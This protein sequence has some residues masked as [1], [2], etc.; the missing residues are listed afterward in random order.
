MMSALK[1]MKLAVCWLLVFFG[2]M[3]QAEMTTLILASDV[4]AWNFSITL[5]GL[6]LEVDWILANIA[7][8]PVPSSSSRDQPYQRG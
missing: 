8:G 1:K 6:I 7:A 5:Q 4:S 3:M 2:L